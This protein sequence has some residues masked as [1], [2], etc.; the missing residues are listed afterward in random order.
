MNSPH[1]LQLHAI[2]AIAA[3]ICPAGVWAEFQVTTDPGLKTTVGELSTGTGAAATVSNLSILQSKIDSLQE[4]I[5]AGRGQLSQG[6]IDQLETAV[7]AL[8]SIYAKLQSGYVIADYVHTTDAST[9]VST[10]TITFR[11]GEVATTMTFTIPPVITRTGD[12]GSAGDAGDD[13]A[14]SSGKIDPIDMLTQAL[15]QAGAQMFMQMA[16]GANANPIAAMAANPLSAVQSTLNNL[17]SNAEA[18]MADTGPN[19][20]ANNGQEKPSPGVA[21]YDISA[22]KV[23][24]PD[25]A[26]LEA[27]SGMGNMMD[28]PDYTNVKMQG[29]T[30]PNVYNLSLRES[31]YYGVEALRLTPNDS[32]AMYGRDGIL[33]HTKLVRGAN[34]GSHG[35]VAFADYA[36][37]LQA[38]KAGQIRQLVVVPRKAGSKGA[39]AACKPATGVRY[40]EKNPFPEGK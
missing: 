23:Y 27:H 26:V 34:N 35:C 37:F 31:P 3:V 25:G 24:L 39:A 10:V 18:P 2:L 19:C 20:K 21:V 40:T 36:S 4:Q 16:T 38:F 12:S 14:T 32:S 13:A 33:A 17:V 15:Q 5:H 28:N 30:P 1:R 6:R 9:L 11:K 8:Q 7:N 29:P 22:G